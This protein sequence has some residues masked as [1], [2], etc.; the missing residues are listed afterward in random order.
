MKLDRQP[1]QTARREI[2]QAPVHVRERDFRQAALRAAVSLQER[3]DAGDIGSHGARRQAPL[4]TQA[5]REVRQPVRVRHGGRSRGFQ[6][7]REAQPARRALHQRATGGRA[8]A[9]GPFGDPLRRHGFDLRAGDGTGALRRPEP[10]RSQQM[11]RDRPERRPRESAP[12]AVLEIAP[13]GLCQRS[14]KVLADNGFPLEEL[15]EHGWIS[16]QKRKRS[17]H[18]PQPGSAPLCGAEPGCARVESRVCAPCVT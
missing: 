18:H 3:A 2:R 1:D 15:I 11:F 5:C 4:L 10:R 9:A 14:G 7:P 12:R 8:P 16:F 6:A 17:N 13:P